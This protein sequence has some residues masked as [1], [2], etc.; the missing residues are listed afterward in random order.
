M[1]YGRLKGDGKDRLIEALNTLNELCGPMYASDNMVCL[2]RS[3]NF[4]NDTRFVDAVKR[5]ALSKQDLSLGWR[6]HTLVWAAQSVQHL[7]G[8]FVECGVWKGFCFGVLTDYLNFKE[9]DRDLYLYDTYAGIPEEYNSEKRNNRP[10]QDAIAEDP[11]HI[12]N[13]VTKR[14]EAYDNVK[15]VRGIV[16][17]SF[18]EACPEKIAL[19]HIDMNSAAS[20]IA[21][22]NALFDKVVPGGMIVFDDYGWTGYKAQMV[23]ED[24]FMQDRGHTILE[25]PTGQGLVVKH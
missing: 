15:V 21:A 4:R 6:L 25:L 10:Y 18:A 1:F 3:G 16:P 8:D 2:Q 5:Q 22:L 19:L 7:E 12:Y 9:Q 14:F 11:D 23:A 13:T 20:E 24:K 17:D